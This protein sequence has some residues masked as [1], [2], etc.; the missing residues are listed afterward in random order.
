M[1]LVVVSGALKCPQ[2]NQTGGVKVD[3]KADINT[4]RNIPTELT[5]IWP[6]LGILRRHLWLF[7]VGLGGLGGVGGG[8]RRGHKEM[9]I[10]GQERR[11]DR[12]VAA[13]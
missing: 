4:E 3:L 8:V 9:T 5:L 6:A 13:S 7:C 11:K 12:K 10:C 2:M 1:W